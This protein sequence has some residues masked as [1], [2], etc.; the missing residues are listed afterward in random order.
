MTHT[1]KFIICLISFLLISL[2]AQAQQSTNTPKHSP[3]K[4]TLYSAILPGLGQAYNKKYWKIPIIYAGIGAFVYAIDFN[5]KHYQ[6]YKNAYQDW[7]INDHLNKRYTRFI[8]PNYSEVQ[9]RTEHDAW[10]EEVL[11]SKKQY[12]KR[13]RDLS[14]IGLTAVYVL[15]IIEAAVDAH[16]FDFNI[17]DDLSLKLTPG[18]INITNS[19]PTLG[20]TFNFRL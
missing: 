14:Y 18:I 10:F 2:F 1:S 5:S 3:H 11:Q 19:E 4:A 12:Y 13:Y 6:L 8:P 15:Q 17:S 20:V 9:I 16:F 7:V